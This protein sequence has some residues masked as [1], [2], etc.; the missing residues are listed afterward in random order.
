MLKKTLLCLVAT[1]FMSHVF[2]DVHKWKDE[3]GKT[4]Y[5]DA[6]PIVGTATVK[7]DKQTSDQIAN[8]KKLR[9]ENTMEMAQDARKILV[10]E[11]IHAGKVITGM[12]E[13]EVIKSIGKPSSV[14]DNGGRVQWVYN[15]QA[16][17]TYVY[18]ENHIVK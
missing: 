1:L 17:H 18:F 12:T 3:N 16:E 9:I 7:V 6:P 15:K 14:N 5:G 8:G 2:A 10:I 11:A 4:H 13:I